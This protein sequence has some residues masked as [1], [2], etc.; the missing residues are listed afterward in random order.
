MGHGLA[1]EVS[2]EIPEGSLDYWGTRLHQ[3][4]ARLDAT[5]SRFG[6]RVLT[7]SDPHG[8]RLAL[9]EHAG[10]RRF[11]AWSDGPVPP[12]RQVRGLFGARVWERDPARTA[13][14]LTGVLGFRELATEHGWTRYGFDAADGVVDVKDARDVPRGAWGVGGVHHLA[15]RVA[16]GAHQ[17]AV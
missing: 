14:F 8:L 3:Y 1:T 2:L 16:D 17:L 6:A 9:V 10:R 15:W 4:G 13:A 5:E 11:E 7:L 12:E